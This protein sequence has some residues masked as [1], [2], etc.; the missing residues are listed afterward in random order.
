[1]NVKLFD[2][3]QKREGKAHRK[4]RACKIV[5][6]LIRPKGDRMQRVLMYERLLTKRSG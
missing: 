6:K 4:P 3:S 5:L 2:P 1:M